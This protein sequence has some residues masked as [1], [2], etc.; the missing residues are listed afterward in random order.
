MTLMNAALYGHE[1]LQRV[2]EDLVKREALGHAYLFFGDAEIGKATFAMWLATR[3]EQGIFAVPQT[4]LLDTLEVVPNEKGSIGIDEVRA[5]KRFLW[6][7]PL[8]SKKRIAIVDHAEAL[9]PEAQ[10]AMLKVVEEPPAHGLL[11][12]VTHDPQALLPPLVSRLS[13][14]YFTRLPKKKI[15]EYLLAGG[16]SAPRAKAIAAD[17]YGRMGRAFRLREK[18]ARNEEPPLAEDLEALILT[19]AKEG[20]AKNGAALAKLLAREEAIQR[21]NVNPNI[22]KKAI[23]YEAGPHYNR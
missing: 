12:F 14:I 16:E 17:A 2:C 8:A 4:P 20:V 6:Q 13:K 19:L 18:T 10:G 22:Q 11:I 3:V 5:L 1:R 15:E 23:E 7:T 21:F 9:T